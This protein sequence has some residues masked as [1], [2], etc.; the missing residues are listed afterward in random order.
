MS[1]SII[2]NHRY[3]TFTTQMRDFSTVSKM[4]ALKY[5]QMILVTWASKFPNTL[6]AMIKLVACDFWVKIRNGKWTRG[7]GYVLLSI[8][9]GCYLV[10]NVTAILQAITNDNITSR[11]TRNQQRSCTVALTQK[12]I[13]L[14]K[15]NYEFESIRIAL[16]WNID[17]SNSVT[18]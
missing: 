18:F 4:Y 16:M 3:L 15:W 2:F 6:N 12:G 14:E 17:T 8:Y 9:Y 5:Y 13:F 10:T 1:W 7:Q 11:L